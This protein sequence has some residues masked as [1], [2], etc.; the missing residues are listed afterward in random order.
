[1]RPEAKVRLKGPRSSVEIRRIE[2]AVVAA[3]QGAN[4]ALRREAASK[5]WTINETG[6]NDTSV[7]LEA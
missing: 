5:G 1:M 2:M 3:V 4:R 7:S 6:P